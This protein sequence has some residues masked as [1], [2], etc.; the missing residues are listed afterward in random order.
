MKKTWI[1]LKS[2]FQN[3][4]ANFAISLGLLFFGILY[5]SD[6]EIVI[7]ED[8]FDPLIVLITTFAIILIFF[9]GMRRKWENDFEK[10]LSVHFG[11]KNKYMKTWHEAYLSSE[12]DIRAWG[13][14]IRFQMADSQLGF[15]PY[16]S[17]KRYQLQSNN[18]KMPIV[19]KPVY[20][21]EQSSKLK[22]VKSA[23]TR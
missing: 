6:V 19:N 3:D 8:I 5:S 17:E 16:I 10:R 9:L 15:Y 1:Y 2:D 18:D 14:Q 11:Y 4:R 7:W 13:Q 23:V 21:P 12:S 20:Y 22:S